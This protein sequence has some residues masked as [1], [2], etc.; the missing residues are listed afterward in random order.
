MGVQ[1]VILIFIFIRGVQL[2]STSWFCKIQMGQRFRFQM[3]WSC[4]WYSS[5]RIMYDVPPG[6][7]RD[8]WMNMVNNSHSNENSYVRRD[9]RLRLALW[10]YMKRN[11][12]TLITAMIYLNAL[13]LLAISKIDF[14]ILFVS[15]NQSIFIILYLRHVSNDISIF[16]RIINH[17][18]GA[19]FFSSYLSTTSR[20]RLSRL[21]RPREILPDGDDD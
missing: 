12:N 8:K 11:V 14:G 7:V 10:V 21:V 3:F 19:A 20:S 18:S 1:R 4:L 2:I 6:P 5:G 17:L 16:A 9:E 13:V 15:S